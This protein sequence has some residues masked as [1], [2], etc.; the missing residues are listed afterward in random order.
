MQDVT[1]HWKK[2]FDV[3]VN[4][5]VTVHSRCHVRFF[6]DQYLRTIKSL[7][8]E[9]C[10]EYSIIPKKII[11]K[12]ISST[13]RNGLVH[14]DTTALFVGVGLTTVASSELIGLSDLSV[15]RE[16]RTCFRC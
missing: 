15:Y 2:H 7:V 12:F 8:C 9:N 16:L 13:I 14:G 6:Q 5:Y 11:G 1:P 4:E 3:N 10:K